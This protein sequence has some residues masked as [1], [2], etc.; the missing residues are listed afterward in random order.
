M[1]IGTIEIQMMADLS[2]LRSDMDQAKGIVGNAS[3]QMQSAAHAVTSAF[4]ALGIGLSVAGLVAFVK[5]GIDAADAMNEI[6]DKTGIATKDIAGLQLAFKQGNVQSEEMTKGLAKMAKQMVEGNDVFDKMGVATRNTDG[7]LRSVKAV[8]Y[9][10]ADAFSQMEGGAVKTNRSIEIFGKSGADFIQ[11]LNAGSAGL[12][13]MAEMADKLGLTIDENTGKAADQ[14]ND[15]VEL[16]GMGVKGV[17]T[18]IAVQLLPTLT[19]LSASFLESMTS[20]DSLRKISEALAAALKIL[21]SGGVLVVEAFASVGKTIGAAGAQV[22]AVMNGDFKGAMN[23]G[24]AYTEDM[25]KSWSGTADTIARAWDT[26]GNSTVQ[27][28]ANMVK[29]GKGMTEQT[30]A[31]EQASKAAAAEAA[32]HA[33]EI[34]KLTKAGDDYLVKLRDKNVVTS[35][36]I[37]LGRALTKSEQ[38]QLD[39]TNKLLAGTIKM[40]P[41]IEAQARAQIEL[42][43][44]SAAHRKLQEDEKKLNADIEA[45][46]QKIIETLQAET[47]KLA[48]NNAAVADQNLQL[49]LGDAAYAQLT[50]TRLLDLAAQKEGIAATMG[51]SAA[52]SDQ[53]AELIRQAALLRERAALAQEGIVIKEAK[54]AA[55]E[56]QKTTDSIGQGL[57]DS[58]FRAFE[59][60]KGFFDTL[61]EGIKN[62]FKTTV[63]KL[64]VNAVMSPITGAGGFLATLTG[65]AGATGTGGAAGGGSLLSSIS[66]LWTAGS[67]AYSAFT[68]GL[69]STIGAGVSSLGATFGSSALSSFGAGMQGVT[70]LAGP[71]LAAN[72]MGATAGYMIPYVGWIA[73]AMGANASLWQRGWKAEDSDMGNFGKSLSGAPLLLDKLFQSLGAGGKLASALSGSAA[74]VRLFGRAEAKTIGQGIQGTMQAGEIDATGYRDWKRKGGFFRSDKYG[75]DQVAL[76]EDQ[77][78]FMRMTTAGVYAQTEELMRALGAPVDK[79]AGV[80]H[81]IRLAMVGDPE[82]DM[83]ALTAEFERYQELLIATSP[84]VAQFNKEGES[85]IETLKRLTDIRT[86]SDDLNQFGGVFSAIATSSVGAREN[87]ISLAGGI[88]NLKQM[89][90]QFVTDYYT[91]SE[92]AGLAAKKIRDT[93]TELGISSTG[94][95][96]RED[97]RALVE[98][99]STK[100][101]DKVAQ[102]QL[103]ALLAL[104][105]SFATV[106]DYIKEQGTTLEELAR[107]APASAVLESMFASQVAANEKAAA[108]AAATSAAINAN[109]IAIFDI[110]GRLIDRVAAGNT[111]VVTAVNSTATASNNVWTN[112]WNLLRSWDNGGSM[113]TTVEP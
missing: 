32:K 4:A 109:G 79:L 83:A 72:G 100:L 104:A 23:I 76:G 18:Q 93:L 78:T 81:S 13:E 41:A 27:A 111:E 57:T 84:Y 26:S 66:S 14:F 20:G 16:L 10:T 98:S 88:E 45:D 9:D 113:S 53:S 75:T 17:A 67:T 33:A 60:G 94:I 91:T 52:T 51:L 77:D 71:G 8:L 29:T 28:M 2:R 54:A 31:Q 35:M 87:L 92:Q 102:T 89:S 47:G 40:T 58:L 19:S 25:K 105:P 42:N 59:A 65:G 3:S 70:Q 107:Q 61:W 68:T 46:K 95:N 36:E 24:K 74:F 49:K 90:A 37:D 73:A 108:D 103:I 80:A 34:A 12:K 110:L 55:V 48:E 7:T 69:A 85:L 86:L 22:V 21:Y 6:S 64:I 56:W 30:K 99:F 5:Q 101:E 38:D 106:G 97:F 50:I 112:V 15:Q 39:L 1:S 44:Q 62:T 82:K 63:L 43:A 11:T 96:T